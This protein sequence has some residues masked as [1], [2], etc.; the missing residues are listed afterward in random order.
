[1]GWANFVVGLCAFGLV[2]CILYWERRANRQ[3]FK[4]R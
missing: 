2:A 3:W 4:K 1:M